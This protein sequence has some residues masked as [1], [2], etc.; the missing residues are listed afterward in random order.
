MQPPAQCSLTIFSV[1]FESSTTTDTVCRLSTSGSAANYTTASVSRYNGIVGGQTASA[2]SEIQNKCKIRKAATGKNLA[3]YVSANARTT[4]T[5]VRTRKN[6][7]NGACLI[8]IGPGAT[9]WFEDTTNSDTLAVGDDYDVVTVTGTGTETMA[10]TKHIFG[11]GDNLRMGL[12]I[13]RQE[14]DFYGRRRDHTLF[15]HRRGNKYRYC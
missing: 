6:A 3:V 5:L 14:H 1:L 7:T 11:L 2:G 15:P 10:V 13:Q 4:D 12:Y 9:G 8:T